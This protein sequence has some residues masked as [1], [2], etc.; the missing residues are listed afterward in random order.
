MGIRIMLAAFLA[1]FSLNNLAAKTWELASPDGKNV[2]NIEYGE[3]G[4]SYSLSRDGLLQYRS[5]P[6]CM[7]VGKHVWGASGMRIRNVR[8]ISVDNVVDVPVPRKA[9]AVAERYNA[10]ILVFGEYDVEFR[11]YD[12]GV[13]Y[14]FIGKADRIDKVYS[15]NSG[16]R[17]DRDYEVYALLTGNLQTWY[18]EDYT[19][20][21]LGG[22][23]EGSLSI[24]PLMVTTE[25]ARLLL[26]ESDLH[27]YPG[28]YL[29][30][31]AGGLDIVLAG[32]PAAQELRENGGKRYVTAREDYL[33]ECGMNRTFPW[34][35]TGIF[36]IGNDTAILNSELIYLLGERTQEDFSW[37]KPGKVLWDWWNCNNITGVD[38]VAGINTETYMY[39]V[40]YA[41]VHGFE[42]VL[43]DEGWSGKND[44]MTLNPDVDM[45]SICRYASQKGVG[46]CL[47]S[48]WVTLDRQLYDALDLMASWGVKGIKVDFMERND[49]EM[50][51]FYERV[52]RAAADRKILVD[53]HSSYPA[54]GLHAKYP[55]VMTRE[56]VIGLEYNKWSERATPVHQLII[57][58][59]RQWA[60]GMD[61]TPGA[62]ANTQKKFF[63]I[64][65]DE[66]MSQGTRC[67][68]MAM[69]VVYESPLQ[70]LSDSPSKYDGDL[71]WLPFLEK[72]PSVWDCTFPLWGRI[73]E[74]IAVARRKGDVY[75][76]GAMSAGPAGESRL[77][78]D[79]LPAGEWKMTLWRDGV[80]AG[81]N[82]VD[83]K[84]ETVTVTN[85]SVIPVWLAPSGGFAAVIE[86]L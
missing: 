79:F 8:R 69:Y 45:P 44:L 47:W 76:V 62:M 20:S 66:P 71:Q 68:N 28:S 86:M 42:Y 13:A 32:Y 36:P 63:R 37:I 35:V 84:V 5:A 81:K 58:Y 67:H 6:V 85:N 52:A 55:N 56:G 82:A 73:G 3:K 24:T 77:C 21:P 49:A 9:A 60:S 78:L 72:V 1:A 10:V 23:P 59:I 50:V 70:M 16:Y 53:F 43:F 51:N 27:N 46:V 11:A 75:F 48:N 12:D 2:V 83:Y 22:L 33:V 4:L 57:P 26:S 15:E 31:V 61:F 38:F 29:K 19:V 40:D 18:E 7:T 14:R 41:S 39:M 74:D 34:R 64:R 65:H 80:N 30:T 25:N 17:F 54:D